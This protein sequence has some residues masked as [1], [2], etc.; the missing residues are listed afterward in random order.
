MIEKLINE[1]INTNSILSLEDIF[2]KL[3]NLYFN[4]TISRHAYNQLMQL[5]NNQKAL[6]YANDGLYHGYSI[7]LNYN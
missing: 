7:E 1:I 5:Y 4:G 2:K 6:V 3:N